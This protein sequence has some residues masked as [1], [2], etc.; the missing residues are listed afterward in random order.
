[1]RDGI[2]ATIQ[3]PLARVG[4]DSNRSGIGITPARLP[5][6]ACRRPARYFLG[7]DQAG[8]CGLFQALGIHCDLNPCAFLLEQHDRARIPSLPSAGG[9]KLNVLVRELGREDRRIVFTRQELVER[10]V[11]RRPPPRLEGS[12]AHPGNGRCGQ[13]QHRYLIASTTLNCARSASSAAATRMTS[14]L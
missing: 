6:M 2:V 7:N 10:P 12:A 1:M 9:R 4:F 13:D 14:S 3:T 5:A 11:D 8:F